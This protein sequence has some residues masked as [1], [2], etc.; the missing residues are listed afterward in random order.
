MNS[1]AAFQTLNQVFDYP[2]S[3]PNYY[4]QMGMSYQLF[5]PSIFP[6]NEMF[7]VMGVPQSKDSESTTETL[8]VT[9]DLSQI[10][11]KKVKK[12]SSMPVKNDYNKVKVGKNIKANIIKQFIKSIKKDATTVLLIRESLGFEYSIKKFIKQINNRL[13]KQGKYISLKVIQDL[14]NN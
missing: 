11:K 1:W 10:E 5:C 13:P 2:E 4:Y 6:T 7:S 14:S 9:K 3:D 8:P 12:M